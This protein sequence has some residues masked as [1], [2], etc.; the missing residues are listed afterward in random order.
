MT[1][2]LG[3]QAVERLGNQ[4]GPVIMDPATRTAYVLV[5]AGT[6]RTWNHPH[7]TALSDSDH[8]VLPPQGKQTPPGPY[9]LITSRR[10]LTDTAALHH[11][12]QKIQGH[13]PDTALPIDLTRLTLDQVRSWSC[14]LCGARLHADRSLGTHTAETGLLTEPTELWACAPAC[15]TR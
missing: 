8:I 1:R 3:L 11:A 13:H 4:A 10:P 7:T 15:R 9:W 2:F 6:T 5:P 14:A 12:L